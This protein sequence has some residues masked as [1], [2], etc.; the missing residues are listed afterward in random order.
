MDMLIRRITDA[1][2]LTIVSCTK[3]VGYRPKCRAAVDPGFRKR[4]FLNGSWNGSALSELAQEQSPGRQD[5]TRSP[6][7][8]GDLL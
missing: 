1:R 6:S 5:G 3:L 4:E 2:H 8:D 7:E